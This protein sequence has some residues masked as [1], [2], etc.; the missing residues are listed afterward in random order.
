VAV[1]GGLRHD[2][3]EAGGMQVRGDRD[4]ATLVSD[5]DEAI[6]GLR[7]LLASGQHLDEVGY[8]PLQSEAAA[9]LF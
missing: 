7:G 4:A 9:A 5:I 6:E 1:A 3:V 8:L 2:R